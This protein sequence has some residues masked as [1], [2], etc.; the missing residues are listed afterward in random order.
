M[1][2]TE[3]E[4]HT[5]EGLARGVKVKIKEGPFQGVIGVVQEAEVG[6]AMYQVLMKAPSILSTTGGAGIVPLPTSE[7]DCFEKG[8][9]WVPKRTITTG[10]LY[11]LLPFGGTKVEQEAHCEKPTSWIKIGLIILLFAILIFVFIRFIY[12]I[13]RHLFKGIPYVGKFVP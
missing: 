6:K 13:L 12:P 7:D 10:M 5:K 2:Q 11:G 3:A 1:L 9:T 8:Y 4:F